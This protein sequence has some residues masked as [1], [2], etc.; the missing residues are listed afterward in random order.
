M[1]GALED[2]GYKEYLGDGV[3]ADYDGYALVLTTEN[4]IEQTNRIVMEPDIFEALC[5]W[6]KRAAWKGDTA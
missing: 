1:R 4:G 6:V 3:Y 5:R 2:H